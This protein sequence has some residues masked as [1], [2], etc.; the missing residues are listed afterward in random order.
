MNDP[1]FD[2]MSDLIGGAERRMDAAGV[3]K[4]LRHSCELCDGTRRD[5]TYRTETRCAA[6]NGRG[7]I[8]TEEQGL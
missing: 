6:C 8:V 4:L 5:L 2:L 7:Y 3:P 1:V